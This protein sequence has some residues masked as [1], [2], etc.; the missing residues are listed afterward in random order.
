MRSNAHGTVCSDCSSCSSRDRDLRADRN[1]DDAPH[2]NAGRRTNAN[3]RSDGNANACA[4]QNADTDVYCSSSS[5]T[6][7]ST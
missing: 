5:S 2:R 7:W 4:Q 6:G 3:Q 1:C